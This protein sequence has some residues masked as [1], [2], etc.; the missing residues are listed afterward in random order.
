MCR[1]NILASSSWHSSCHLFFLDV[2]VVFALLLLITIIRIFFPPT[3]WLS[4]FSF[5][6]RAEEELKNPH[7]H[8]AGSLQSREGS[9]PTQHQNQMLRKTP[10]RSSNQMNDSF[11]FLLLN[12]LVPKGFSAR[13]IASTCKQFQSYS[14]WKLIV[15]NNKLQFQARSHTFKPQAKPTNLSNF[16]F[17]LQ[18]VK[19]NKRRTLCRDITW[20]RKDQIQD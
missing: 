19:I 6:D 20:L 7:K 15:N 12:S 4:S 11:V 16:I 3:R 8:P 9:K 17:K 1:W 13:I 5:H 14:V 18:K 10:L 2:R